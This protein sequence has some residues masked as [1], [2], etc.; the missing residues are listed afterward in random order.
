M[1]EARGGYGYLNASTLSVDQNVFT[2]PVWP[3]G[4]GFNSGVTQKT[5]VSYGGMPQITISGLGSGTSGFLGAARRTGIR[6]PEGNASFTD[7]VSYLRGKH[8]FKFGFQY[9]DVIYDNNSYNQANGAV[10][11]KTLSDLPDGGPAERRDSDR[12]SER[13]RARQLVWNV[14]PGRLPHHNRGSP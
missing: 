11:F 6:G 13:S 9:I 12:K 7:N 10:K 14:L 3:T 4:Y 2:Q 8:A 1:N 5:P